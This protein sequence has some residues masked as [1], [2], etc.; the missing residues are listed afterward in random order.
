MSNMWFILI[1]YAH[2]VIIRG[3]SRCECVPGGTC[4]DQPYGALA[5][6]ISLLGLYPP[7]PILGFVRCCSR[8]GLEDLYQGMLRAIV[9]LNPAPKTESASG[10]FPSQQLLSQ[11]HAASI[12]PNH[13]HTPDE[14]GCVPRGIC[15]AHLTRKTVTCRG[16]YEMCCLHDFSHTDVIVNVLPTDQGQQSQVAKRPQPVF[17]PPNTVNDE[18]TSEKINEDMQG[19]PCILANQ[20]KKIY[21]H[22][23]LDVASFGVLSPCSRRGYQR[24]IEPLA[25][26]EQKLL[27]QSTKQLDRYSNN[28]ILQKLKHML[29]KQPRQQPLSNTITA[30]VTAHHLSAPTPTGFNIADQQDQN[31]RFVPC[32]PDKQCIGSIYNPVNRAHVAKYGDLTKCSEGMLRCIFEVNLGILSH[33]DNLNVP[34]FASNKGQEFSDSATYQPQ[35]TKLK[36][37]QSD[38]LFKSFTAFQ[39]SPLEQQ[40]AAVRAKYRPQPS[41]PAAPGRASSGSESAVSPLDFLQQLVQGIDNKQSFNLHQDQSAGHEKERGNQAVSKLQVQSPFQQRISPYNVLNPSTPTHTNSKLSS[42]LSNQPL[43]PK[44]LPNISSSAG[45]TASKKKFFPTKRRNNFFSRMRQNRRQNATK[46]KQE[47]KVKSTNAKSKSK[48]DHFNEKASIVEGADGNLIISGGRT[49]IHLPPGISPPGSNIVQSNLQD[50]KEQNLQQQQNQRQQQEQQQQQ[51]QRQQYEQQQQ[52]LNQKQKKLQQRQLHEQYRR[53][54]QQLQKSPEKVVKKVDNNLFNK[55]RVRQPNRHDQK[56]QHQ[57]EE[58]FIGAPT[59]FFDP[60]EAPQVVE[61]LKNSKK[62]VIQVQTDD[63]QRMVLNVKNDQLLSILQALN[64]ALKSI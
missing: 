13:V 62:A 31:V 23:A 49:V 12:H 58:P 25:A 63:N 50:A 21:G 2:V 1:L 61:A 5:L 48:F 4:D 64:S 17:V 60:A 45:K 35:L 28:E 55:F 24:C 20:C 59:V 18:L 42:K 27:D 40:T 43:A 29:V 37:P 3:E 8:S 52:Q 33:A 54:Q 41:A 53:H 6:D 34:I 19:L 56:Q 57:Q 16:Q 47:S 39:S 14:C 7:C 9:A 26:S 10:L 51:K 15:M 22:D 36:P 38:D 32:V 11:P 46:L 30:P 44:Q